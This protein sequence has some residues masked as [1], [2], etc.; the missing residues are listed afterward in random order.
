[1]T[2]VDSIEADLKEQKLIVIGHMDA[3]A[4]AKKLKKVGRVEI[5]WVGPAKEEEKE[6]ERKEVKTEDKK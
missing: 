3:I 2:G 4:V 6:E 1:M 5:L